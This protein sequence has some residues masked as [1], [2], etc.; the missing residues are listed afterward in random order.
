MEKR[1]FLCTWDIVSLSGVHLFCEMSETS[2]LSSIVASFPIAR[3]LRIRV[4]WKSIS[5]TVWCDRFAPYSSPAR[6]SGTQN[7]WGHCWRRCCHGTLWHRSR[8]SPC[9]FICPSLRCP[10]SDG[11]SRLAGDSLWLSSDIF[12]DFFHEFC[13]HVTYLVVPHVC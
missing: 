5:Q 7:R 2:L 13:F 3:L 6:A 4:V 12:L 11:R 1:S 9:C 10:V 8:F